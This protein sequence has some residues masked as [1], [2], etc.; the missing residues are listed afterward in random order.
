MTEEETNVTYQNNV[1]EATERES[2]YYHQSSVHGEPEIEEALTE[3]VLLYGDT[4]NAYE[5]LDE[6]QLQLRE[7][8][9]GADN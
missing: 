8:S 4:P 3:V 7:E 2:Y 5:V 1:Y 9:E 6:E